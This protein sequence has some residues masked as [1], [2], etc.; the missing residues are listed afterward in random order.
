MYRP[1]VLIVTESIRK[2][3]SLPLINESVVYYPKKR[4]KQYYIKKKKNTT[5]I[6]AY[7]IYI[8][9]AQ[10]IQ[11]NLTMVSSRF[12][13]WYAEYLREILAVPD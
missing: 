11:Y 6:F 7:E 9:A 3:S 4:P 2:F 13:F 12:D 1:V 10:L 8:N 5:G